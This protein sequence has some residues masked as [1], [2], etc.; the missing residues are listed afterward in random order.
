MGIHWLTGMVG[1]AVSLTMQQPDAKSL[2]D[3]TAE[4]FRKAEGVEM[5]FTVRSSEG[6]SNGRICLKGAKF[7][8][9]MDGVTT[10]FDG[11]TQWTYLPSSDEVTVS[12]PTLEELQT[13]NPYSWLS[14]YR[15]D[16]QL[17][18]SKIGNETD[19]TCYKVVMDAVKPNQEIQSLS[20][21]IEK[22]TLRPVQ[23]SML[24]RGSKEE[25][26]IHSDHYLSGQ[27]YP[28]SFFVFD[29]AAHPTAEVIDLR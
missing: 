16:Y 10:W 8:L 1:L 5:A 15:Q 14:L 28:D 21:Y 17:K 22:N 27:K 3:Q 23:V 25:V 7:L 9:E 24:L 2:L 18:L 11:K 19:K 12:Q 6:K 26:V 13:L 20:L 29:N 4:T